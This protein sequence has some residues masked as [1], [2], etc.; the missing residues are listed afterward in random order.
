MK[1]LLIR[2]LCFF[3]WATSLVAQVACAKYERTIWKHWIDTDG[4]CHNARHE[5]LIAGFSST[6][7]S[8]RKKAAGW[9]QEAG[10]TPI[11]ERRSL[12][13]ASSTS[14]TW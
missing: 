12:R 3:G 13:L 6:L 14:I 7:S 11:P 1:R 8:R 9:F 4:D 5:V 10:M 2:L